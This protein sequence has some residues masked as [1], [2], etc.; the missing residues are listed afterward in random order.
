VSFSL[1]VKRRT[2]KRL[3]EGKSIKKI[4]KELGVGEVT[5]GN[6]RRKRVKIRKWSGVFKSR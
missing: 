3:D 5:V 2:L 6:W 1:D 4:V